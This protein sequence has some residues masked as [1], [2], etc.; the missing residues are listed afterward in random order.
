MP[1]THKLKNKIRQVPEE[2]N[3]LVPRLAD[4]NLQYSL[5]IGAGFGGTTESLSYLTKYLISIDTGSP[6]FKIIDI[7]SRCKYK[8]IQGNSHYSES[9]DYVKKLLGNNKLDLLFIDGDHS[10]AGA[11]LDFVLYE[12]LVAPGGL[13]VFHDIV[14]SK[15]HTKSGCVVDAVWKE[16]S[17][18]YKSLEIVRDGTWGGLGV[19]IK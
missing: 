15:I 3:E 2:W 11:K 18:K 14:R 5:E 17:E 9:L 10:F 4:A 13:I 7:N 19:C 8:Y 12:P 1:F 16:V 6:R